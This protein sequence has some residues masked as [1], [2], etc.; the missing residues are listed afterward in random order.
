MDFAKAVKQM[1]PEGSFSSA[2]VKMTFIAF[3]KNRNGLIDENEFISCITDARESAPPIENKAA[4]PFMI[5]N[6]ISSI[7]KA[8]V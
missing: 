3:D 6:T 8:E 5:D 2:D 1:L 4:Q 7:G